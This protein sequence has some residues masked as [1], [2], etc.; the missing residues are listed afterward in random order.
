MLD[1][2]V[3]R[4]LMSEYERLLADP[5]ASRKF[6]PQG[7]L[8]RAYATFR[9]EFGPDVLAGL[10]GQDLLLKM[11]DRGTASLMY[12]LE[13]KNDDELPRVFGSISGGSALK[14]QLF[15]RARDGAW[16]TGSPKDQRRIEENEAAALATRQRDLLL[17]VAGLLESVE[18][19]TSTEPYQAIQAELDQ[20][21][22]TFFSLAWVHMYLHLCFPTKVDDYHNVDY[23][24]FH[25]LKSLIPPAEGLGR[26]L[27]APLYMRFANEVGL[28]VNHLSSLLNAV[29]GE[30][31]RWYRLR[32]AQFGISDEQAAEMIAL[33][34][35]SLG[36][37][38]LPDLSDLPS[39][40]SG[41]D[42]LKDQVPTKYMEMW[43]F[44]NY[45]SRRD[46]VL[47][48]GGHSSYLVDVTGPY[49]FAAGAGSLRHRRSARW[50]E[51]P[52][53][54]DYDE[55]SLNASP[56]AEIQ[57]S[58]TDLILG[59]EEAARL[60]P[61]AK[62]APSELPRPE[63]KV[64]ALDGVRGRV[65][66]GLERRRQVILY[67][68]PG[69]GKT[70]WATGAAR[71]LASRHRFGR[72]WGGLSDAE[73]EIVWGTSDSLVRFCTFH[74]AYGYEDFIEGFRPRVSVDKQLIFELVP[75]VFRRI[76]ADAEV[77]PDHR[78]YL[79]IDEINRGDI[80]RIFGELISL[81]ESDKRGALRAQLPL[82]G[83][84]FSVPKNVYVIGTMNTA[85]R[86]IALLD[87]ALRRRFGFI[88]LMPDP[89]ALGDA[90]IGSF[91]LSDLLTLLNERIVS[92]LGDDGR[93]LQVGHAYLLLD[94]EPV[95]SVRSFA[96]VLDEE[97]FPLLQEYCYG[98]LDLLE[99]IL[100]GQ[101]M[102]TD[103]SRI[104][105]ALLELGNEEAFLGALFTAFQEL[106]ETATE[107]GDSD[108]VDELESDPEAEASE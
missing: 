81:I 66:Q 35:L 10:E 85:D 27:S 67:G 71:E 39:N 55:G 77:N 76:C 87:S 15:K 86:S 96:T 24:R 70:Y 80:P 19:P 28:T 79:L 9:R 26:Y 48:V 54:F 84:S 25:L 100:G 89:S 69:T 42:W 47:V 101:L 11:H 7:E 58:H 105:P 106:G 17:Q 65:Q 102:D 51:L 20:L 50:Y 64:E 72:S 34:V 57:N 33:G 14:F 16:I 52:D 59:I 53:S 99:T 6:L 4:D 73:R 43:R 60:A 74:P 49:E 38:D 1:S 12:W 93:N 61:E 62:V 97:I 36:C 5:K 13:F 3:R 18:D 68:P 94:G 91:R 8:S 31:S 46:R 22:Y 23:Q 90:T 56:F 95:S 104:S 45:C 107:D 78:Y 37:D 75:G 21:D 98:R 30:P 44:L 41:K 63:T 32:L 40:R 103:G 92:S 88:E 108:V 29:Q 2:R 83:E 82:S